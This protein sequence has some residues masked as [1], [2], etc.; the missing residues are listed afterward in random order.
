[1]FKIQLCKFTS[2][3]DSNVKE[4]REQGWCKEGVV[5]RSDR[6]PPMGPEF[7]SSLGL[8]KCLILVWVCCWL[9]LVVEQRV[10]LPFKTNIYK[11]QFD[12]DR[13]CYYVHEN[14]LMLTWQER[15]QFYSGNRKK[16]SFCVAFL[17][18]WTPIWL[19]KKKLFR[20]EWSHLHVNP[21]AFFQVLCNILR[22]RAYCGLWQISCV[23]KVQS[24]C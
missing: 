10:F 13:G 17:F 15:M 8:Y 2:Q 18:L 21:S 22:T 16:L 1:M 24:H 3:G 9:I 23:L 19:T 11:F 7:N 6:L 5:V 20:G 4:S 12:Q 14:Q